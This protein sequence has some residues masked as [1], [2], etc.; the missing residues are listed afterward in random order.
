MTSAAL[1][2][3]NRRIKKHLQRKVDLYVERSEVLRKRRAADT[4]VAEKR[5]RED[6]AFKAEVGRANVKA[7]GMSTHLTFD[8]YLGSH[9][10]ISLFP[11]FLFLFFLVHLSLHFNFPFILPGNHLVKTNLRIR[12]NHNYQL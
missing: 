8:S 4:A 2:S 3:I 5:K 11:L 7:A 6:E 12:F 10:I 9:F 1:A